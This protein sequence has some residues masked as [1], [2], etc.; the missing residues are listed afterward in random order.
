MEDLY[1][2]QEV[3]RTSLGVFKPRKIHDL[4]VSGDTDKWKPAFEAALRQQRLWENRKASRE[5]PRKVPYKF[6]YHFECD[7]EHCG[8]KHQMMIEDW[9]VGALYWNCIDDGANPP[10]AAAK[11]KQKFLDQLCSLE[12]DTH[13][14][15]G[16]IL[17]HPKSWVVI[18]V[19]WPKAAIER[20]APDA[21]GRLFDY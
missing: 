10:E 12:R 15:V 3:D 21:S 7:D 13:F 2:Q 8:R 17:A 16:T 18:G 6:H 11:V 19:F 1:G 9:E 4:A 5:P 14:F 20:S